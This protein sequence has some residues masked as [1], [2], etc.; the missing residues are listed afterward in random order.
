MEILEMKIKVN[1][2]PDGCRVCSPDSEGCIFNQDKYCVLKQALNHKDC[3][4]QNNCGIVPK[5][6]PLTT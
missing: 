4:V 3:F 2:L 5:N 6:C 1:K